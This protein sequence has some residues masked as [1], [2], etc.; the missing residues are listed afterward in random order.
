MTEQTAYIV[1]RF[2]ESTD[3][4]ME[5]GDRVNSM[6]AQGAIRSFLTSRPGEGSGTHLAV[7]ARSWKPV[8]VSAVQQTVL[9]LD[10]A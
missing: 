3:E 9:T 2:N 4:W 5:H 10:A 7:P 6:S 8:K 1:L